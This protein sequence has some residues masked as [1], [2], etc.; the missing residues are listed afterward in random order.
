[1]MIFHEITRM[2]KMAEPTV[3]THARSRQ[4]HRLEVL[5]ALAGEVKAVIVTTAAKWRKVRSADLGA[6]RS[7]RLLTALSVKMCMLQH[8]Q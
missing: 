5:I 3:T 1:M 6:E 7:E 2:F 4:Q 8:R